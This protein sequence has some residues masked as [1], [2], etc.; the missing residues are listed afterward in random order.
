MRTSEQQPHTR[1]TKQ[2]RPGTKD[3]VLCDPTYIKMKKKSKMNLLGGRDCGCPWG[4][5]GEGGAGIGGSSL[6][7]FLVRC[8]QV[9]EG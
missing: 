3:H 5:P 6:I 4:P 1:D 8:I 7:R 2:K 9:E